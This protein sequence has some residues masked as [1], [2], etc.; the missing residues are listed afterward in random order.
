MSQAI[1]IPIRDLE[2]QGVPYAVY[3]VDDGVRTHV[4]LRPLSSDGHDE[5]Y[6]HASS[7]L[8]DHEYDYY[9]GD[10]LFQAAVDT[11]K[12]IARE[13]GAAYAQ[14][15]WLTGKLGAHHQLRRVARSPQRQTDQQRCSIAVAGRIGRLVLGAIRDRGG[16]GVPSPRAG[17]ARVLTGDDPALARTRAWVTKTVHI[18]RSRAIR[19][20][21]L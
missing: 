13:I 1:L 19:D 6:G 21:F 18:G 2:I 17:D 20:V 8:D 7:L 14:R 16:N 4:E 11:A 9:A 3:S 12:T 10:G 15:T 5:P